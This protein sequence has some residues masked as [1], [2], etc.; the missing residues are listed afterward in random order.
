MMEDSSSIDGRNTPTSSYLGGGSDAPS[1]FLRS[2]RPRNWGEADDNV[3]SPTRIYSSPV[4]DS[5]LTILGDIYLNVQQSRE[6]GKTIVGQY[7]RSVNE[8]KIRH[9]GE[10]IVNPARRTA[11][12]AQVSSK[13]RETRS[14]STTNPEE[15]RMVNKPM[16]GS[17][18]EGLL[19]N[20]QTTRDCV[21]TSFNNGET[22]KGD[23]KDSYGDDESEED[24]ESIQGGVAIQDSDSRNDEMMSEQNGN[25]MMEDEADD[26]G[27]SRTILHT[28]NG[29]RGA[30][31]YGKQYVAAQIQADPSNA[32]RVQYGP[33]WIRFGNQLFQDRVPFETVEE[34]FRR[35]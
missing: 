29:V 17:I 6:E 13:A 15:A 20:E 35:S 21:A 7:S 10:L 9:D 16:S 3:R 8:D 18:E 4:V 1:S 22:S 33:D 32:S 23:R 14:A 2:L 12:D 31:N 27:P 5:R 11:V 28:Y 19:H 34:F 30:F 24:N 26:S 25:K